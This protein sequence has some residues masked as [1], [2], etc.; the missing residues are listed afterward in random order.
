MGYPAH[1][2]RNRL[3]TKGPHKESSSTPPGRQTRAWCCGPDE[4]MPCCLCVALLDGAGS[5]P[6]CCAT[7]EGTT[8]ATMLTSTI[9][10]T[11][12]RARAE[13][14]ERAKRANS[15]RPEAL[16]RGGSKRSA[17]SE[18][19]ERR[20]QPSEAAGARARSGRSEGERCSERPE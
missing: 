15:M 3:S 6:L 16:A 10:M 20:K 12:A 17:R 5:H 14:C 11:R 13:C 2:P 18:Q 19:D 8:E 4:P 1:S 7:G 9:C